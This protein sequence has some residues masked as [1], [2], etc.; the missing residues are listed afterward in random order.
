MV[1][2]SDRHPMVAMAAWIEGC[3]YETWSDLLN[4]PDADRR[5]AAYAEAS[6]FLLTRAVDR[7]MVQSTPEPGA[8]RLSFDGIHAEGSSALPL[9]VIEDWAKAA[10]NVQAARAERSRLMER[11]P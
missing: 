3:L 10:R 1:M 4:I 2:L 6:E 5:R 8:L 9:A 7:G 11:Q